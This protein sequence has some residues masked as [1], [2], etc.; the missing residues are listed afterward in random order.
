MG[1]KLD[2]IRAAADAARGKAIVIAAN[3]PG[4]V[5]EI[6]KS[7]Q[8]DPKVGV[9]FDPNLMNELPEIMRRFEQ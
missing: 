9:G 8:G 4:E 6:K 2:R 3:A 7:Q 1:E 5:A